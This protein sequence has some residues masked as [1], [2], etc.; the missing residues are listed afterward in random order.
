MRIQQLSDGRF[1][2]GQR[3]FS[4]ADLVERYQRGRAVLVRDDLG[5]LRV[6]RSQGGALGLRVCEILAHGP[7]VDPL[8]LREC[9]LRLEHERDKS[10]PANERRGV[11]VGPWGER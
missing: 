9:R 11:V 5:R 7:D 6:L 8:L 2:L 1:V 10:R 3:T 4:E